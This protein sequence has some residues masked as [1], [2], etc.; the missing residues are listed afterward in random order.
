LGALLPSGHDVVPP[1]ILRNRITAAMSNREPAGRFGSIGIERFAGRDDGG[2]IEGD[3]AAF[4]DDPPIATREAELDEWHRDAA[5]ADA[6]EAAAAHDAVRDAP[7]HE[8]EHDIAQHAH[9]LTGVI[10]DEASEDRPC[11][12]DA[13]LV[14]IIDGDARMV[15]HGGRPRIGVAA[16]GRWTTP[17]ATGFL[18]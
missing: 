14:V 17:I 11:G 1:R 7:G 3:V 10:L 8:I 6:E 2:M 13:M 12:M 15:L 5:L 4:E 9:R 18:M 16:A